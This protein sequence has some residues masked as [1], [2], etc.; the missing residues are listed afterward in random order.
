MAARS[1]ARK[2]TQ[3]RLDED[4]LASRLVAAPVVE[5]RRDARERLDGLLDEDEGGELAPLVALEPVRALLEGVA[6]GSPFLWGL[7]N[8][9]PARAAHLLSRPPEERLD[10][11]VA[12]MAEAAAAEDRSE[13]GAMLRRGRAEAA[14]LI[15]LA[16]RRRVGGGPRG[17]GD[18]AS[19]G[20][21]DPR[22]D[23]IGARRRA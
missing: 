8:R 2:K 12:G 19:R 5:H 6:D 11:I 20:S 14:L 21:R 17:G 13:L 23:P 22:G 15:A 3:A 18:L 16:D 10:E 9:D 1:S 4:A 7:I